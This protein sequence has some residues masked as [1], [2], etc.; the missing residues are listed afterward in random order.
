MKTVFFF[1]TII[2][3]LFS[4]NGNAQT[5]DEIIKSKNSCYSSSLKRIENDS[6]Y[7]KVM[8]RFTDTFNVMKNEKQ[9]FGTPA[10][11]KKIDEAIFF[12][13]AKTECLLI[14]LKRNNYNLVF[15]KAR[16][17]RGQIK[18]NTWVF[19]PSME[20]TYSDSYFK[21]Y[22]DNNFENLS[23]LARYSVLTAGHIQKDGCELD[24]E[25]WFVH[26]KN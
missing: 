11:E 12:N 17:V 5:K 14:V 8:A 21:A 6:L 19:E 18:Q 22:S 25:Y 3:I 15:G 1:V 26:M 20:Y 9:Y 23:Q 24:E 16:I 13:K 2:S 10:V 7:L 4:C